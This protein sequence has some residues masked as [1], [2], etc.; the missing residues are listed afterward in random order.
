MAF[1]E[2][3]EATT[4]SRNTSHRQDEVGLIDLE[5]VLGTPRPETLVLLASN[6]RPAG[7]RLSSCRRP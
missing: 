7:V 1:L 2:S 4:G 3:L 6:S 5:E